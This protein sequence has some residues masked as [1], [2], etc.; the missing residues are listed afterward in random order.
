MEVRDEDA[1]H[2]PSRTLELAPPELLC[3]RQPDPRVDERPAVVAWEQVG[4]DVPRPHGELECDL[5]DPSGKRVHPAHATTLRATTSERTYVLYSADASRV[6][7]R[8]VQN[9]A[10]PRPPGG[11]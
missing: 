3:V 6:P 7:A 8:A 4:V 2:G 1:R 5:A 9:P 10:E 11:V